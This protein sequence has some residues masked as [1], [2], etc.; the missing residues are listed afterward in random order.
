MTD[1]IAIVRP[2]GAILREL[3]RLAME[4]RKAQNN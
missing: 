2:S 3:E 1:P 4:A